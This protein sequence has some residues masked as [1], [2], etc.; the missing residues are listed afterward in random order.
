[1]LKLVAMRKNPNQLSKEF[2]CHV[3]SI[4]TWFRAAGVQ[5]RSNQSTSG[6]LVSNNT[7]LSFNEQ[8]KL[9]ELR[10]KLKRVEIERGILAKATT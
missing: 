8:Q 2:G 9:T 1:M 10:K 5:Y 6:V 7:P 4:Q 3:T